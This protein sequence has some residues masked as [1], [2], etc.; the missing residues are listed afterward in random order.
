MQFQ[1]FTVPITDDGSALEELNKFLRTHKTLEVEQQL[2]SVKNGS[3]WHFCVKYL[4]NA[5][6]VEAKMPTAKVDYKE[7]LDEATFAVFSLL[8]ESR[9]KIAPDTGSIGMH[10][11]VRT[12]RCAPTG[13]RHCKRNKPL[14]P[15]KGTLPVVTVAPFRGL[16]VESC[17][18]KEGIAQTTVRPCE[19]RKGN[20]LMSNS[21]GQRPVIPSAITT[22]A[23]KGRKPLDGLGYK[24]VNPSDSSS[25]RIC[26]PAGQRIRIYN[27]QIKSDCK[28]EWTD[29][30]ERPYFHN[31]RSTTCGEKTVPQP[32][33]ER[34]DLYGNVLPFRQQFRYGLFSAGR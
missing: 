15:L 19:R 32:L 4:A 22:E 14:N 26:N 18:H 24:H 1:L 21:T 25:R 5:P 20:A 12:H 3:Q 6:I 27:P 31:R 8:R 10:T 11:Q 17:Q 9:K 34:Q 33:P 7:V 23:L 13:S 28:S 30:P 2:V 29:W 16:G